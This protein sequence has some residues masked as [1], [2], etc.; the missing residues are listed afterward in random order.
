MIYERPEN[1]CKT[2]TDTAS[3]T[4]APTQSVFCYDFQD[5]PIS[6]TKNPSR[7]KIKKTAR[8]SKRN[9]RKKSSVI[10]SFFALSLC[11]FVYSSM[12]YF[13]ANGKG[14]PQNLSAVFSILADNK[15]PQNIQNTTNNTH[16]F[17]FDQTTGS[18]DD[19]ESII[20]DAESA[21]QSLPEQVEV[22]GSPGGK[23][24][25]DGAVFYPLLESDLSS[26][27]SGSFSNQT[28]YKTENLTSLKTTPSSL[29]NLS[30]S[31]GPLVLILHTHATECYCESDSNSYDV[32]APTR[33]SD[34]SK[35]VVSVGQR[36]AKTLSSF[37]ISVIH[38]QTLHDEKSFIN[39]YS[40]SYKSAKQY[41]EEYPSIKF[42]IDVHRDSI[43]YD[44]N[45]KVKPV[46]QIAG[47]K[48]AQLMFVVGTDESSNN[49]PD[50]KDNLSL[51]Q[52]LRNSLQDMYPSICRKTN[53]RSAS[54]NQQ[55]S[56]GYML[57]EV[58]SCANTLEE[59]LCSADAFSTVL[60][61]TILKNVK[62]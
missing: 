46:C 4:N 20:N 36:I 59:A 33:N 49:H 40:S 61:K 12:L 55:L 34:K 18:A 13:A 54:F 22:S 1:R 57:L 6:F 27:D 10:P 42:V 5:L 29:E 16:P 39:A 2:N 52:V 44:D 17:A 50:W 58:G 31:D 11:V 19:G 30:L 43:V 37:G 38:D 26:S 35:N 41:L 24:G 8:L 9:F 25:V 56:S 60:G 21:Y 62:N 47:Q 48:Y 3:K 7:R 14:L 23:S 32:S 53:I 15:T 51:T 28:K 45:T